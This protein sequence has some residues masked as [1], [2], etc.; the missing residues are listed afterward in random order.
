MDKED[1]G[2]KTFNRWIGCP[3]EEKY[4]GEDRKAGRV[5]RKRRAKGDRSKFK[6]TDCKKF[7]KNWNKTIEERQ[8]ERETLRGRVLSITSQGALVDVEG[9]SY[10]CFLRGLLKK[11]RKQRKN[12]VTVG[13]FV[14]F[15]PL[16]DQEGSILEVE[17][18]RSLLSRADNLSRNKEHL[19]AANIDQVLITTSVVSPRLKP[20]LIDRYIIAAKKGKMTPV[21]IINKIDLLSNTEEPFV[22]EEKKLM[23]ACLAAYRK[24][25]I[26][27]ILL[28]ASDGQGMEQLATQMKGKSSVFSGQSGTGKSSLI[29]AMT[30]LELPVGETVQQTRKG[31]HTTTRAHLVPLSKGG[32]CID[33]PGIKSFGIW[34]LEKQ[35]I[36]AYFSEIAAIGK[37]CRFPNCTHSHE[38][39]CAVKNALE[40]EKLSP[41]RYHSYLALIETI[42]QKHKRR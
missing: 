6:K 12:L 23:E 26:P 38:K 41:L 34:D 16:P 24:V 20:H 39:T 21:I 22:L 10:T 13:D 5:E 42:D 25:D 11:E 3:I 18:R 8:G 31:A 28:S 36:E 33:T 27:M 17:P 35:E 1:K 15:Q 2:E 29:N 37:E 30:G 14:K 40:S 4:L 7:E 19:I 32:W 9:T